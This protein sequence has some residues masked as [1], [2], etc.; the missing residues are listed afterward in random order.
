VARS[1][2]AVGSVSTTIDFAHQ[3]N[4]DEALS[5]RQ[6]SI[7]SKHLCTFLLYKPQVLF[8]YAIKHYDCL[9]LAY[10]PRTFNLDPLIEFI[11]IV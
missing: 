1:T 7:L 11:Y 5:L 10:S 2:Q 8:Q 3:E 6:F 9:D 4:D